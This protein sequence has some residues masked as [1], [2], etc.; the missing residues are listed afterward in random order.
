M[1]YIII[2]NKKSNFG[3]TRSE[4]EQ[5][6]AKEGWGTSLTEEQIDKC[7]FL[8]R[9]VKEKYGLKKTHINATIIDKVK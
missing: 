5:N 3:K 8:E 4:Q 2:K 1:V 6:L 7:A 9:K